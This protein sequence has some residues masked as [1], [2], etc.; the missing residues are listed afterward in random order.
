MDF[1]NHFN[2]VRF[3]QREHEIIMNKLNRYSPDGD[4]DEAEKTK[5]KDEEKF[6]GGC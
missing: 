6:A 1:C 3:N 4:D 5:S 2:S